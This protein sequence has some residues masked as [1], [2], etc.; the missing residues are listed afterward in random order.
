MCRSC[1][2]KSLH[3]VLPPPQVIKGGVMGISQVYTGNKGRGREGEEGKGKENKRDKIR[4][5]LWYG[6]PSGSV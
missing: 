3:P 2:Q 1:M 4:E 5:Y 6:I